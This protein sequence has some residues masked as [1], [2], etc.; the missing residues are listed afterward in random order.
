[1][2]DTNQHQR[3]YELAE[4]RKTRPGDQ[5]EAAGGEDLET[6]PS[7]N[8]SN[9]VLSQWLIMFI[10]VGIVSLIAWAASFLIPVIATAVIN[11]LVVF[12][13]WLW[14]KSRGLKPPTFAPATKGV[15]GAALKAAGPGGQAAAG[16]VS[17][18]DRAP[19]S[20]ILY[21]ALGGIT[22]VI[23][24]SALWYNNR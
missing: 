20:D 11:Y 17:I 3:A 2:P 23:Y 15:T 13:V 21:V 7:G 12:A 22:P 10:A 24:L 4:D 16:A 14:A 9:V 18:A 5:A 6:P 1:M 8:P 19:G